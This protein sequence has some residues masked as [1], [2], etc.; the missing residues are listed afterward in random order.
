MTLTDQDLLL[1][2]N[3]VGDA[4]VRTDEE[5]K[6]TYGNDWSAVLSPAPS[7]IVFPK[8]TEEVAAVLSLCHG[9][10]WSVVP[11]GGRTG[12]SG[13]AVALNGEIVLSLEKMNH[14]S[15]VDPVARTLHC[16]SGAITEAVH[17]HTHPY[18]L[19]WPVDFASKG[20]STVGGN[21]STNAGGVRVI[22]YGCTRNWVLGL[23]VVLMNGQVL[24]LDSPLEKNN[25]GLD[26]KQIFVGTEGTLGIVTECVLRLAP[27]PPERT[28][29]MASLKSFSEVIR[30]FESARKQKFELYAFETFSRA[31]LNESLEHL[32]QLS[33]LSSEGEAIVLMEAYDEKP[34][35][36]ILD[37]WLNE[38]MEDGSIL[39]GAVANSSQDA[40]R[41]WLLRETIAEAVLSKGG[42][43]QQDVSVPL[44][45]LEN[46]GHMVE[47][48]CKEVLRE[49]E[50]FIFGHIGDGN[51]HIFVRRPKS[52]SPAS[53]E[54][55]C[56]SADQD[57]FRLIQA[58]RGSI[59]AE[60]GVGL[61]KREAL[62]YSR[63]PHEIALIQSMKQVFD[64][65]GLMNPGKIVPLHPR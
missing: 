35:R 12:L 25:T 14:L 51:L 45:E 31:C 4:S 19:T 43:H 10:N 59:S 44:A 58:H 17:N 32:D 50:T 55:L 1:L 34:G 33:P 2:K 22:R 57:L 52:M 64:P 49:C 16:E 23:K 61:L 7:A 9:K 29:V 46:F 38:R 36:P 41:F 47:R 11:S 15:K 26:L 60:H 63:P 20:S 62:G 6:K 13:G 24:N 5:S 18:G 21:I 53:F 54:A 3:I 40:Q 65:K 30:L 42:G 48:H 37:E 8:S 28:V 39:D 27:L 56:E